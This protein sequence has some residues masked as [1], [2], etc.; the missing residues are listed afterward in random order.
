MQAKLNY[1]RTWPI[2]PLFRAKKKKKNFTLS[3]NTLDRIKD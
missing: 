3:E 2:Q 1:A